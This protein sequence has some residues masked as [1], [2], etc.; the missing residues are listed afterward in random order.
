M[1]VNEYQKLAARTINLALNENGVRYHSLFG[2]AA[3][4]GEILSIYQKAYQG[5]LIKNDDLKKEIGDLLWMIAELCT[6]NKW[7][8]DDICQMN[9]DKL[10]ARYPDGFSAERSLYRDE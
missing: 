5:H 7:D 9:I 8:M 2:I 6:I 3:E 1:T 10:I 4:S